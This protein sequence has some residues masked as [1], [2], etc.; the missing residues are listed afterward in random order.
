MTTKTTSGVRQTTGKG[1]SRQDYGTPRE[2]LDAVEKRF[3]TISWDLAAHADNKKALR[4]YG[5]GSHDG[6]DSFAASWVLPGRL[7]WLNPP[8][9]NIAPW[10]AKCAAHA[11]VSEITMLVPAS[12]GS[13]WFRDHVAGVADT[14]LL[15]G[16]MSF[17]GQNLF[18]KDCLLAHYSPRATGAIFVW[19]WKKD[20]LR[21]AFRPFA[22]DDSRRSA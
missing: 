10:A 13:N 20:V 8:F 3:G 21:H 4:W 12:V 15:N 22:L 17:D 7:L 2:F 5:P 19:D 16:R 6:E 11:K 9:A 14:Y 1:L 18:P